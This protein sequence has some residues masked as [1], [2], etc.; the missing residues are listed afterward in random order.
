MNKEFLYELI[1]TPSPSGAE[2]E[3]QKK[4]IQYLGDSYSY[5]KHHSNNLVSYINGDNPFKIMLA[6]H[7]DEIGLMITKINGNGLCNVTSVGGINP[8]VYLASRVQV[9]TKNGILK[10]IFGY[11]AGVQKDKMTVSDL[12]LDLGVDSKEEAE[13]LVQPGDY[14]VHDYAYDELQNKRLTA[15]ALDNRIGAFICV[16]ALK[17]A[18]EMGTKNGVY[19][20]TTV[21]EETTMRGAGFA[22]SVV[23][24][25]M[26]LVV[27]VT[28]A[29]DIGSGSEKT[30][31]IK[32]GGGPVI[33]HSSIANK[34]MNEVL[35]DIAKSKNM[36]LQFEV[37]P[38]RTG[39]DADKI[40]FD[41]TGVPVALISI[42]L[43][44]MH[45]CSEL[46]DLGDVENIITLIAEF[47]V[48]MNEN[49]SLNPFIT[50]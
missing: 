41:T 35:I 3:I 48:K 49:I 31:E 25:M 16:E 40:H 24:P 26:A 23:K 44:Y 17:K 36:P 33:C 37:A 50:N 14:I 9:I 13:K 8:Y 10:G 38:G 15:R 1:K 6:G 39:T 22:A 19:T 34:K 27:D 12:L 20:A 45:S 32:L 43:R 4:V 7:I 11:G 30:G 18:K 46:C 47:L 29:T 28:Y 5:L 21:G 2:V 42:P